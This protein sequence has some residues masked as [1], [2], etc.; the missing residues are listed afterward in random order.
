MA[1]LRSMGDLLYSGLADTWGR[2]DSPSL[3]VS[4]NPMRKPQP[5]GQGL[6]AGV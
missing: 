2:A 4:S 3:P 1:Y 6:S 5:G